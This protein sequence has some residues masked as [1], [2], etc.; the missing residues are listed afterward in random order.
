MIRWTFD[1]Y[2]VEYIEYDY[3]LK[4]F[5]VYE[6]GEFIGS[7]YPKRIKDL[8]SW[9]EAFNAYCDEVIT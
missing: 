5:R 9:I 3:D 1:E 6:D 7:I 4:A 8:M 2:T